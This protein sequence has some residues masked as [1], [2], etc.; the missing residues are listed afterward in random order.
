MKRFAV[1]LSLALA[2]LFFGAAAQAD[3][4]KVLSAGVMRSALPDLATGFER[5]TG[6]K[7]TITLDSAGNVKSRVQKGE[8]TDVV[9][10]PK[11]ELALLAKAR[12]IAPDSIRVLARTGLAVGVRKGA[13][14]PDIG[15]VEALKKTLLEA[16][17]I[18]YNDPA[19]G[20]ADGVQVRR[21]LQRL[22][23]A[24]Q[25]N[26]K[27]K[28]RESPEEIANSTD[29][30]IY[31]GQP[32]ALVASKN[33]EMVGLLPA[34][35]QNWDAFTWA[36]GVDTKTQDPTGAG[37]LVRYLASPESAN[38]FKAKGMPPPS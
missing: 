6:V 22:G 5:L 36:A 13:P 23:I 25:M 34:S 12:K 1:S 38:V 4:L 21:V 18:A 33:Y 17:S 15:S 11:P 30:D 14:K 32:P 8:A 27:T 7:L 37:D 9:I 16:K 10:L 29:G 24:K 35:L 28:L 20:F 19:K 31:I 26:A 2:M 3:E